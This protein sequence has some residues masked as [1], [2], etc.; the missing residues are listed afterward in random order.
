L[1]L[2]SPH[3]AARATAAGTSTAAASHAAILHET[4]T[5]ARIVTPIA[6]ASSLA[7]RRDRSVTDA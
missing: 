3:A 4:R 2:T 7:R 1:P 5:D 6:D